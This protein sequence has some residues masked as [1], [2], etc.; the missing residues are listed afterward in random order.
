M[1]CKT[2][3]GKDLENLTIVDI[4]QYF[5]NPL[6]ESDTVEYKSYHENNGQNDHKN[7]EKSVL[8]TICA[9]LNSNGGILI[10]GAPK[11]SRAKEESEVFEKE[12]SPIQQSIV[13]DNFMAKIAN[14]I[15]PYTDKVKCKFIPY[16]GDK[17]VGIF[18]VE[19]SI[20]RPHQ[21]KNI[22]YMRLDGQT[23]VAPHHYIEALFKQI[24]YPNIVGSIGVRSVSLSNGG[25]D[26]S[27]Q[28]NVSV[29]NISKYINAKNV[30]VSLVV[31]NTYQQLK[32]EVTMVLHF[33][34]PF[35]KIS[36]MKLPINVRYENHKISVKLLFGSEN[37]PLKCSRYLVAYKLVNKYPNEHSQNLVDVPEVKIISSEENKFIF[38]LDDDI[39]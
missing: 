11:S 16:K 9:F 36:S 32:D 5:Q 13:K 23:K 7:K 22:Y 29:E 4:V 8:K 6:S 38:D 34:K 14:L 2:L 1:N 26:I 19:K 35:F 31:G 30:L 17:C 39:G 10:W 27:C 18:E 37:S 12:L 33:G 20:Y 24:S 21:F 15:I 28:V 3:F 25:N